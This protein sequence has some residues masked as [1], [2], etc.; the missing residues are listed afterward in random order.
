VTASGRRYDDV[1]IAGTASFSAAGRGGRALLTAATSGIQPF[2]KGPLLHTRNATDGGEVYAAHCPPMPVEE[3]L[4]TKGIRTLHA[5]ARLF[6]GA[7]VAALRDAGWSPDTVDMVTCGTVH[8]G[9]DELTTLLAVTAKEGADRANPAWAAQVGSVVC[10]ARLAM[11]VA[12]TGPCLTLSS[13]RCAGVE[14]LSV[15][16]DAIQDGL[17]RG[18]LA[19]GIDVLS[20]ASARSW[21]VSE[22]KPP[23]PFDQNRTGAVP[24]EAAAVVALRRAGDEV[25]KPPLA[26]LVAYASAIALDAGND[27]LSQTIAEVITCALDQAGWSPADLGMVVCSACGD[28]VLDGCE[29]AALAV[30]VG[31]DI[32]VWTGCGL[33]GVTMGAD[34]PLAVTAAIAA[35]REN[36]V[37]PIAGLG[38]LDDEWRP[39]AALRRSAIKPSARRALCL[40]S[41]PRGRAD[42]VLLSV[43]D[44]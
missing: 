9:I 10:A 31:P 33:T 34:G 3:L 5:E 22:E 37:P 12:A 23:R 36:C 7:G 29:A 16:A 11:Q 35:L 2:R 30:T 1:V 38:R 44:L 18:V 25:A 27:V 14:A 39:I 20:R 21:V 15:G 19:G 41:D 8:T 13:G 28:P 40:I 32:P 43:E 24:G 42:V 6:T 4:G 17:V 26:R